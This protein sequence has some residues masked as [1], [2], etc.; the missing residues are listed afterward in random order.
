MVCWN[1]CHAL[2]CVNDSSLAVVESKLK[3]LRLNANRTVMIHEHIPKAGGM[4]L[5][6]ALSSSC[7]CDTFCKRCRRVYGKNGTS[8]SA[9]IARIVGWSCSVHPPLSVMRS[10]GCKGSKSKLAHK[11]LFPLYIT[12][13]RDPW[14][15]F[16]SEI[17]KWHHPLGVYPDWA[18]RSPLNET[19]TYRNAIFKTGTVREAVNYPADLIVHNRN[20]KMLGGTFSSFNMSHKVS[21]AIGSRWIGNDTMNKVLLNAISKIRDDRNVLV[22]IQE[23]FQESICLLE[24]LLGELQ[25]FPWDSSSHAHSHSTSK[26]NRTS[27]IK[28]KPKPKTRQYGT[29]F[30]NPF[31]DGIPAENSS[32][33]VSKTAARVEDWDIFSVKNDEHIGILLDSATSLYRD[34]KLHNKDFGFSNDTFSVWMDKNKEDVLLYAMGLQFFD[35]MMILVRKKLTAAASSNPSTL[36]FVPHCL[37]LLS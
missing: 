30:E 25:T 22:L 34:F 11:G 4:A 1:Q 9:L 14:D 18:I 20:I 35:A 31:D 12:V 6:T 36:R 2:F 8:A 33:A 5:D 29:D 10:F 32:V 19:I 27:T 37:S 26:S 15:R 13:L 16:V 3:F 23:R 17:T 28:N 7:V 21:F 24:Y